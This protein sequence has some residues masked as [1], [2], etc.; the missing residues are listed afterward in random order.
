MI[1]S[2]SVCRLG[3]TL[4][5]V[6]AAVCVDAVEAGDLDNRTIK[7]EPGACLS[8][9]EVNNRVVFQTR[10]EGFNGIWTL[11]ETPEGWLIFR[12]VRET[13]K[14]RKPD[15]KPAY[16]SYRDEQPKVADG[17]PA[18]DPVFLSNELKPGSY[19]KLERINQEGHDFDCQI[20]PMKGAFDGWYLTSGIELS[21]KSTPSWKKKFAVV[22]TREKRKEPLQVRVDGL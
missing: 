21:T 5:V 22:L 3:A 2:S 8:I 20:R 12:D 1:T 7:F 15:A 19:W 17:E 6:V 14:K 4:Y 11:R 16:L 13:D 9:E 18:P 10:T